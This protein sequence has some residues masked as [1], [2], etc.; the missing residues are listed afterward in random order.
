MAHHRT[1]LISEFTHFSY[2]RRMKSFSATFARKCFSQVIDMAQTQPVRI[3]RRGLDVAII[4]SSEEF[5]RL[6]EATRNKVNPAVTRLHAES[7]ARWAE[8]YRALG[9]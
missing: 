8:V 9:R 4:M 7:A 2:S 3:Q 6:T 1:Q 5:R